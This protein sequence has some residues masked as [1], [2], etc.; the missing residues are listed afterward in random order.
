VFPA[1]RLAIR[2]WGPLSIQGAYKRVRVLISHSFGAAH[3]CMNPLRQMDFNKRRKNFFKL[4]LANK[5]ELDR[6]FSN[7][8]IAE[9]AQRNPQG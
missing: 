5:P 4:L 2:G 9:S 3:S 6:T 8:W 1:I 7:L